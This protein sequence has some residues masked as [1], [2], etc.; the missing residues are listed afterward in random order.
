VCSHPSY[1]DEGGRDHELIY[2]HVAHNPTFP[3]HAF[4]PRHRACQDPFALARPLV[5]SFGPKDSSKSAS[6]R[7]GK[8]SRKAGDK[9]N[10]ASSHGK[11]KEEVNRRKEPKGSSRRPRETGHYPSRR[12][13]EDREREKETE[14]LI[15]EQRKI[16]PP[17]R[18][19]SMTD[20]PLLSKSP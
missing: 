1:K 20:F 15:A 16:T 3:P 19:G 2:D 12:T 10:G 14:A 18:V 5:S 11:S 17:P 6:P 8:S 13:R 4:L 7:R 9:R